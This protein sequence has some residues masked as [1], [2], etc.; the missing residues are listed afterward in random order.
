MS[1]SFRWLRRSELEMQRVDELSKLSTLWTLLPS[2]SQSV[3]QRL[4][5]D[6]NM[7]DLSRCG[8]HLHAVIGRGVQCALVLP[9]W[10]GKK[11]WSLVL[12][13]SSFIEVLPDMSQVVAPNPSGIPQWEF[14]LAGF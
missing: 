14:V 5:L 1:V 7:P 8:P 2:F 4:S 6:V 9:L 12:E 13:H 11:W 10:E 3:T